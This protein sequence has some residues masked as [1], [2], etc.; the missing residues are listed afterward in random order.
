MDEIG[1]H[2]AVNRA[3]WDAIAGHRPPPP[4]EFFTSG[5]S[6]LDAIETDLLP[7]VTG[8]SLLHLACANGTDSLSWAARGAQVTGVDISSVG[9][10]VARESASR[11]GIAATFL[12]ADMFDLPAELGAF[13]IVYASWGVVCWVPDLDEWMRIVTTHLKPGGTFALFEHHP[14]WEIL[15]VRG[16]ATV[17]VT[18]DYFGRTRPTPAPLDQSKRP[19]GSTPATAFRSFLWPIGDVVTAV[20][21]AGLV[22]DTLV[23]QPEPEMWA[24]L[25]DA[26]AAR[27]PAVYAVIARR[28][29]SPG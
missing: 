1:R 26:A 9:I 3:S 10:A 15:G 7:D 19:T 16:P 20:L 6:T 24:G 27:L 17:E 29:P 4:A 11:A 23:E 21:R 28:T 25:D 12:V 18:T 5:G 22:L 2:T 13:D 14:L 8:R